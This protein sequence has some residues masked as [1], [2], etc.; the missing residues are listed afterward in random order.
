MQVTHS[1]ERAKFK[2]PGN[3]ANNKSTNQ[4]AS[5]YEQMKRDLR[6]FRKSVKRNNRSLKRTNIKNARENQ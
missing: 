4:C 5:G 2:S 3:R 1:T 6:H